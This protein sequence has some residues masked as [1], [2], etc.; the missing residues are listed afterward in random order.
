MR[1]LRRTLTMMIT[2]VTSKERNMGLS[3]LQKQVPRSARRVQRL[4]AV[5]PVPNVRVRVSMNRMTQK[6]QMS[7]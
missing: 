5:H 2:T 6:K 1:V 3:V 7:W 4:H